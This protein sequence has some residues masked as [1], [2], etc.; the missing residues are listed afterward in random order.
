MRRTLLAGLFALVP[1]SSLAQPSEPPP[2]REGSAELSFVG[3][4]GNASTTSIGVGGT[5]V[6][7]P[8]SWEVTARSAYV[9]SDSAG[10]STAEAFDAGLRAARALTR[11]LSAFGRY[12]YLRDRFAG[13]RHRNSLDAGVSALAVDRGGHELTG[14]LGLGYS[15]ERRTLAPSRSTIVAPA[16]VLY[17][18]ELSETARVSEDFQAVFSL[19]DAGDRR[20]TNVVAVTAKLTSRLS[21]KVS[22]TARF[23]NEPAADFEKVDTVTAIALVATF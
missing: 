2:A 6:F 12:A 9:R 21:L 1:L 11:R 19:S 7:R 23:V 13:I 14:S 8:E 20:F 22:N 5:V 10:V 16:G 3:T 15:D 4:T 17:V 18:L